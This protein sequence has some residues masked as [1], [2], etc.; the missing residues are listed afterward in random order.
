MSVAARLDKIERR[1]PSLGG[2]PPGV[3]PVL[4][5]TGHDAE[6]MDLAARMCLLHRWKPEGVDI[7]A[8]EAA[9]EKRWAERRDELLAGAPFSTDEAERYLR[10]IHGEPPPGMVLP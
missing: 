1:L 6:C 8:T 7:T 2:C 5:M 9:L 3:G 4:W 10:R